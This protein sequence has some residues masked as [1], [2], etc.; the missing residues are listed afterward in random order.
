MDL[1]IITHHTTDYTKNGW[2][3]SFLFSKAYQRLARWP[4]LAA[5]AV[6]IA[7]MAKWFV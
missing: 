2:F 5:L 3:I 7:A 1:P 4:H 6:L